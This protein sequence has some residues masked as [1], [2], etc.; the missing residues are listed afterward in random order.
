MSDWTRIL[1]AVDPH[2]DSRSLYETAASLARKLGAELTLLHVVATGEPKS[3]VAPPERIGALV[4]EAGL[5]MRELAAQAAAA[6][7]H[8]V[9]T[10]IEHGQP[11][12]EIL[13]VCRETSCDLLI[14]GTHGR[15]GLGRAI[16][17]SVAEKLVRSAPC[18]VLTVRP[19]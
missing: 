1:C 11:A 5:P 13:R 14:L 19:Q 16:F 6:L 10:K 9:A 4:T 12:S 18:P 15:R 8:E 7:G 2:H 17:G 3:I